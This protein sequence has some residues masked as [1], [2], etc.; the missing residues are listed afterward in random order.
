MFDGIVRTLGD[1]QN[2]ERFKLNPKSKECRFLGY[3]EGVKGYRLWDPVAK[4]MVIN[5]DVIFNDAQM[6]D[7]D[8][9]SNERQGRTVEI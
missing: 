4:K 8:A 6:L 2:E 9:T 7:R 3:E 1:L 5:R